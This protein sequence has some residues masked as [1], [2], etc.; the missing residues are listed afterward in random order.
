M[1]VDLKY[2]DDNLQLNKIH[3]ENADARTNADG[4]Y[5][6]KHGIVCQGNK[7]GRGEGNEGQWGHYDYDLCEWSPVLL[8]QIL[9]IR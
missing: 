6:K 4:K 1:A 8:G 5:R 7:E 9:H 2:V 3:I